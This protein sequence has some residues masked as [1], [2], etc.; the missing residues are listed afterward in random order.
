[1]RDREKQIASD[2]FHALYPHEPYMYLT[3]N[4]HAVVYIII[5]TE[6]TKGEV[7]QNLHDVLIQTRGRDNV[8]N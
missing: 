6:M 8:F 4:E 2:H 3:T 1:M 5:W 7:P